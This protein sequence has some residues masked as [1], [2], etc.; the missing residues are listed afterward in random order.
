MVRLGDVDR[1]GISYSFHSDMP[2]APAQPLF[3]MYCAVNRITV[4][5]RV[6]CLVRNRF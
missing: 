2:I 1:A 4:S 3:L 6:M 5:G